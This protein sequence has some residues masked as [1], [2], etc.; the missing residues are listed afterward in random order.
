M[1]WP[2]V[3]ESLKPLGAGR[4]R[5]GP[6]LDLWRETSPAHTSVLDSGFQTERASISVV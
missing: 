1:V 2:R 4:G 5:K 3:K 6:S